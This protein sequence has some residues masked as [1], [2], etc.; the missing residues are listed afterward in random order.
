MRRFADGADPLTILRVQTEKCAIT[1]V[2]TLTKGA[3][4]D[5]SGIEP[6]AGSIK[7]QVFRQIEDILHFRELHLQKVVFIAHGNVPSL[8]F[9]KQMP[10]FLVATLQKKVVDFF[11]MVIV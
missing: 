3:L 4:P 11:E 9:R 2:T 6:V 10:G 1:V 8:H 5:G 7:G